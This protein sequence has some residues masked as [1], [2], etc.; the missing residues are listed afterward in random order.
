MPGRSE[1][2]DRTYPKNLS[3]PAAYGAQPISVA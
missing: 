2:M 1:A 3:A